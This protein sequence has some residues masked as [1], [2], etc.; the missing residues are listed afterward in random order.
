[1]KL[2]L[3]FSIFLYLPELT[4]QLPK[5]HLTYQKY[6]RLVSAPNSDRPVSLDQPLKIFDHCNYGQLV[7]EGKLPKHASLVLLSP[8][9]REV[10]TLF[11]KLL[12]TN[13]YRL[14]AEGIDLEC[15]SP[16]IYYVCLEQESSH[17]IPW[18][19]E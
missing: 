2:L 10:I 18:I 9:G 13:L 1:M 4:A 11:T 15:L 7:L 5:D 14:Y 3:F 16:G 19:I 6:G 17:C 12:S 8:T